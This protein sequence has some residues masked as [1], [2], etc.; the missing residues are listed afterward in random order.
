MRKNRKLHG[1]T[2]IVGAGFVMAVMSGAADAGDVILYRAAAPPAEE[3]ASIMFPRAQAEAPTVRT[4]GL[5]FTNGPPAA[6]ATAAAAPATQVAA[7]DPAP[8]KGDSVGFNITFAL[9]SAALQPEALPYLDSIGRLLVAERPEARVAIAGHA[10]A[11]GDALY[12][13]KLSQERAA[14]VRAY[15]WATY[16]IAPE[17]MAVVGYGESRPLP[18]TDPYDGLN[19]RVEFE[20]LS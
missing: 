18:G 13:M 1:L 4:R 12:N 20:P 8:P 5:R 6:T 3:L 2:R 15:L 11:R 9:N 10:D 19:R 17:R 7:A 14:A 16:G